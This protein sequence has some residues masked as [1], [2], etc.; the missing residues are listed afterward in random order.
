MKARNGL[1]VHGFV[2][3][4]IAVSHPHYFYDPVKAG[5]LR[6]HHAELCRLADVLVANSQATRAALERFIAAEGLPRPSLHVAPLPAFLSAADHPGAGLPAE[7]AGA[8]FVLY[9]STLE[10]RKNHRLL[11]RLWSERARAGQPLPRL[12]LVG[13]VGWAVEEATRMLHHDPALAGN[14]TLLS[15]VA[16]DRLA[17]LYRHCLFCVYP[18]CIEGWGL[19][20]TEALTFGKVCVHA[21]DPAQ[22]EASQGLVPVCHPDDYPAWKSE[23]LSLAGDERRRA[24]LEAV[25]R[26]R[27]RPRSDEAFCADMRA[28]LGFG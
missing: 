17:A 18:S 20:I 1:R 24:G 26:E 25:I 27:F 5:S 28:A 12:V 7:L 14:V 23:I 9:V 3:D 13:R 19:P 15:D 10:V 2:H 22:K 6:R 8:P 4:L 21:D 11:L 16:D